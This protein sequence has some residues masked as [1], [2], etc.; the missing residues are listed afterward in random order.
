MKSESFIHKHNPETYALKKIVLNFLQVSVIILKQNTNENFRN[1]LRKAFS[2]C[3]SILR[4][5]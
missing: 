2:S 5:K 1:N 3:H 4:R